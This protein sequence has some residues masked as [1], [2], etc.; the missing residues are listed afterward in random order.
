MHGPINFKF[1]QVNAR[2][3]ECRVC[4]YSNRCLFLS[5]VITSCFVFLLFELEMEVLD[6]FFDN[7]LLSC[8]ESRSD[9][10]IL[11]GFVL[12]DYVVFF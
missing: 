2:C 7:K 3:V 12:L 6:H 9:I 8:L 10:T 1:E 11:K 4:L 5:V